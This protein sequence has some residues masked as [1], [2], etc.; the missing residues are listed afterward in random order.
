MIAIDLRLIMLD[1]L[2]LSFGTGLVV[3]C[4]FYLTPRVWLSDLPQDIQDMAQPMGDDEKRLQLIIGLLV[5]GL[6]LSGIVISTLRFGPDQGFLASLLHAY[7]V[8]Q[9]FNWFDFLIL[10]CGLMLAINPSSP[11]IEGTEHAEGYRDFRFHA[12]KSLKGVILGMPFAVVAA[13]VALL[14]NAFY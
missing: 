5:V 6:L 8:F 11:P 1:G 10:D 4:S 14:I 3:V 2:L 13:G 9:L 7:L 12:L